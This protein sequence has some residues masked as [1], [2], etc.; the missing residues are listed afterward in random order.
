L[1]VVSCDLIGP[2]GPVPLGPSYPVPH[3]AEQLGGKVGGNSWG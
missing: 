1:G 2:F 3:R